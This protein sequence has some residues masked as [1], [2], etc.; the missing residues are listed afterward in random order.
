M[1]LSDSWHVQ[2]TLVS[3]TFFFIIYSTIY[4]V[5][6]RK[7]DEPPEYVCRLLTFAHGLFSSICCL[8]YICFPAIDLYQ[9][10]YELFLRVKYTE[11]LTRNDKK[12]NEH[13]TM[14]VSY[15]FIIVVIF[16][17]ISMHNNNF[18]FLISV[19]FISY[20]S[21]INSIQINSIAQHGIFHV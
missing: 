11:I 13:R 6:R 7:I 4:R 9:G 17:S 2:T 18:K 10:I 21:R 19:K 20:C 3:M 16:Y 8:H 15:F 12:E 14:C 1:D 5:L